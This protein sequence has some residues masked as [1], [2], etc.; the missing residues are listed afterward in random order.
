M[1]RVLSSFVY[2]RQ[3]NLI[4]ATISQIQVLDIW[5]YHADEIKMN[6]D[7]IKMNFKKAA[8]VPWHFRG[9]V[10]SSIAAVDENDP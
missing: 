8:P 6:F 1:A 4:I 7:E 2:V 10:A 9:S 5:S 3:Y